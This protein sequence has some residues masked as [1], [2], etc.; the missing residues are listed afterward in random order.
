MWQYSPFLLPLLL[1]GFI[2]VYLA[3]TAWRFRKTTGRISLAF[4][5]MEV[6]CAVWTLGYAVELSNSDLTTKL[7][8]AKIR[9]IGIVVIPVASFLF[10]AY[11]TRRS[12][13]YEPRRVLALF[14]IP[15]ITL[16]LMW[17]TESNGLI[18]SQPIVVQSIG[19]VSVLNAPYG[20]WF[21]VHSAYSYLMLLGSLY[22]VARAAIASPAAY[23]DQA[24][25][26]TVGMFAPWISNAITIFGLSPI[27]L[28]PF[29][30]T[31][32]GISF[33]WG[34]LRLQ[35]V[36]IVPIARDV[37]VDSIYDAVYVL[38]DHASIIDTNKA[39]RVLLGKSPSELRGKSL[40][41]VLPSLFPMDTILD[42]KHELNTTIN[43]RA[44]CF[45][46][47]ISP[48]TGR[49]GG[50]GH[51]VILHDITER[52]QNEARIQ[53][54]NESLLKVNAQL[55][56]SREK[57]EEAARLKSQFLATM[58]H[59][60]R[61]PLNAIMGY[62][63]LQLEGAV[64]ELTPPQ[65]HAAEHVMHNAEHLLAMINQILDLSK[66]EAG[67]LDI[68]VHP[69]SLDGWAD[70]LAIKMKGL[71]EQKGLAFSIKLDPQLPR[72]ICGDEIRLTQIAINLL[73]NAIKFTK[74]G[75]V[76][77]DIHRDG[78]THWKFEV[79]DT[80][81]GIPD[82]YHATI[83]E[84]FRQVDGSSTREHQ[85]TGLGLTIVQRLVQ[86]MEG[87]IQLESHVGSGTT[88]QVTLPLA[89]VNT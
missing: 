78:P 75:S 44:Y 15:T 77:M 17:T 61:T 21:W 24:F 9:Y 39:A 67:R 18:W 2:S 3:R 11:Y 76:K 73:S 43:G 81:I 69:F 22:F 89:E 26:L 46:T 50:S 33:A 49:T 42:G 34:V 47:I 66:I 16:L 28:T 63:E 14:I 70:S 20:S 38:D 37:I 85:G 64:G 25:A 71:A 55:N 12:F 79:C 6:S 27:D 57:A 40:K 53:S 68:D 32:T 10:G 72:T 30:F 31:V 88:F 36:A 45:E 13:W 29:A 87:S 83:F 4:T 62:S 23:R 59:E 60:L 54:Q 1:S 80:G 41:L 7:I 52:Q 65:R 58:S 35:M 5:L 48:L 51:V 82:A 74:Q 8:L 56:I 84:E 19:S 86:L